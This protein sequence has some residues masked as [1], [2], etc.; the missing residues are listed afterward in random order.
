MGVELLESLFQKSLELKHVY[1]T[2]FANFIHEGQQE[3]IFKY[4][5]SSPP[6][7]FEV[8]QGDITKFNWSEADFVLANS[9]CFDIELM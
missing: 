7:I 8:F 6:P 2:Q 5:S 4:K 1:E 3:E 9:T